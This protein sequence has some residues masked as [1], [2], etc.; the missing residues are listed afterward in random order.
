MELF[1]EIEYKIIA[2][3]N[4]D[5]YKLANQEIFFNFIKGDI[6]FSE[7][8]SHRKKPWRRHKKLN[9]VIGV[10]KGEVLIYLKSSL[11]QKVITKRLFLENSKLI[12]IQ[13][14]CW[15]SFENKRDDCCL[16]FAML[17]GR[18]QDDEVERL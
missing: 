7:V 8:K 5:I 16:L 9:C 6:Y 3:E 18:H 11:H 12:R 1:E 4:G 14:G 17:D 13:A 10:V 15:Y 2:N